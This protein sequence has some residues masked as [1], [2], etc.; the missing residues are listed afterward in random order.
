MKKKFVKNVLTL[1]THK[2]IAS[3]QNRKK[4]RDTGFI[5]DLPKTVRQTINEDTE[6]N[7]LFAMEENPHILGSVRLLGRNHDGSSSLLHK[8]K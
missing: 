1:S 2:A 8:D 6:F 4:Y 5:D 3:E 7:V